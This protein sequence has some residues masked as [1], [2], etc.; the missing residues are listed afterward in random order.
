MKTFKSNKQNNTEKKQS[1]YNLYLTTL[2]RAEFIEF[3]S[4]IS[5]K[6]KKSVIK[7]DI[8]HDTKA[9]LCAYLLYF[10]TFSLK[11]FVNWIEGIKDL[12]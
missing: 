11:T 3:A 10:M 1:T 6:N 2:M 7:G 4:S 9:V 12:H 8:S 5:V